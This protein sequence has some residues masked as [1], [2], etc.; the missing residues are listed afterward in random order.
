MIN[1]A[2]NIFELPF[3]EDGKLAAQGDVIQPLLDKLMAHPY[4]DRA[5]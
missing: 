1:Y 4:M 5:T 3:D 2:L